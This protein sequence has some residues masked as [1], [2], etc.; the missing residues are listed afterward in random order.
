M[1][2]QPGDLVIDESG[3]VLQ[4]IGISEDGKA[5]CTIEGTNILQYR[6]PANLLLL[7]YVQEETPGH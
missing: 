2:F 3:E 4:F 1:N 5:V 7:A 6:N